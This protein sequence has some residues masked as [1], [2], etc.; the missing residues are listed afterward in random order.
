MSCSF[1]ISILRVKTQKNNWLGRVDDIVL[2]TV[3]YLLT[4]ALCKPSAS[5]IT[6]NVKQNRTLNHALYD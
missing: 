5:N 1:E 6:D 4:I 2:G 3:K